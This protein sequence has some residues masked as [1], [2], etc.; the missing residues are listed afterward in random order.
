MVEGN[1]RNP[2]QIAKYLAGKFGE[3]LEDAK[4]R[5]GRAGG[6]LRAG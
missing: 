2:A 6:S 1:P 3:R 5:D 4:R